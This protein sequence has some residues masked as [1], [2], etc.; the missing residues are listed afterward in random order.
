MISGFKNSLAALTLTVIL[1]STAFSAGAT[2]AEPIDRQNALAVE[3]D[4]L[5]RARTAADSLPIVYNIFDLA[6][7]THRV[8]MS[9][10]LY[11]L[12]QRTGDTSVLLDAIR[13]RAN[14]RH[15]VPGMLGQL[16]AEVDAIEPSDDR[17]ETRLFIDMLA[18]RDSINAITDEE[19]AMDR[20]AASIA[21]MS[22]F[23]SGTPSEKALELYALCIFTERATHGELLTTFVDRLDKHLQSMNLPNGAVIR[24]FYTHAAMAFAGNNN[25]R[26]MLDID[27]R[28]LDAMDSLRAEYRAAGRIYRNYE[29]NRFTAL[30]RIL[31]AYELLE[32][33]ELEDYYGRIVELARRNP[34][35]AADAGNNPRAKVFYLMAHGRYR[36]AM[37]LLRHCID[38][39]QNAR[40]KRPLLEAMV[41]AAQETG[42]SAAQLE[43]SMKLNALL[44][45]SLQMRQ[46]DNF[47]ELQ[48]F[49]DISD[50]VVQKKQLE[51]QQ[52]LDAEKASR[53]TK[54]IAGVALLVMLLLIVLLVRQ[55][56]KVRRLAVGLRAANDTLRQERDNLRHAQQELV[57]ARDEAA[58]ADRLKSE[59][60]N[61]MSHEVSS[62]LNAIVEYSRLIVDCVPPEKAQYL[63]R[64]ARTIEFN[65]KLILTLVNDV[66]DSAALDK[67]SIAV[68][69]HP[70][71]VYHMS[72]LAIDTVFGGPATAKPDIEVVF[73]PHK[74]PDISVLT[75]SHRA[76][77]VLSNLLANAQK[78]TEKGK[79][80]VD[81]EPDHEKGIVT[82]S[83]TDTGIGVPRG[84]EEAIFQRFR[85]ADRSTS[86]VGLGLYIVR[87]LVSL[88]GGTVSLDRSYRRGSRF[89]FTLP[90]APGA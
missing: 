18:L 60:V 10:T 59:F 33:S 38:L 32:P 90:L 15:A 19:E 30:R 51:K 6:L 20:L 2:L 75:D 1:L 57:V 53:T 16:R 34:Q 55:L 84:L 39:P 54:T 83:V 9:D 42:D 43:A 35:I 37:P 29:T 45:Y 79:I 22:S 52:R 36:E 8:E 4:K 58:A 11:W 68:E 69:R 13:N 5:S 31:G 88:L 71:S 27:R 80:T 72:A 56:L 14:L 81:F 70:V 89:L 3:H 17:S 73:N 78:F 67:D 65:S 76:V 44:N 87:K 85:K 25:Q 50:L 62:P 64:F 40:Y 77:Q 48:L 63:D 49:A 12:A 47:R 74:R 23:L 82:F 26:L 21:D 46:Q 66:L 41:K 61:V 24:L 7:G 86:G 28:M